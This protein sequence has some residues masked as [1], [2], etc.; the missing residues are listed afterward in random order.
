MPQI[1]IDEPRD[2]LLGPDN[3]LVIENGDF[4]FARGLD[5]VAQECRIAIQMFAGEWFLDLDAGIPYWQEILGFKPE[6][7]IRAAQVA[8][9]AELL[10]VQDVI[11]VPLLDVKYVGA[12][13]TLNVRWQVKTVLGETPPDTIALAVDN[14]GVTS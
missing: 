13:R 11:S 14:S 8:F 5:A 1:L 6:A 12:T 10:A 9:T 7:A 2:W 3:D 4:V